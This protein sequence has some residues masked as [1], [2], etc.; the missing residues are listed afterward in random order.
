ML[1]SYT[2]SATWITNILFSIGILLIAC[3]GV[4][5]FCYGLRVFETVVFPPDSFNNI[6]LGLLFF[7]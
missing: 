1:V 2:K 4:A 5:A 7:A 6:C 3:F